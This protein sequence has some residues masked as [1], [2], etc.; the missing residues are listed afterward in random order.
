MKSDGF[1]TIRFSKRMNFPEMIRQ[2][3]EEDSS[4]EPGRRNLRSFKRKEIG[5]RILA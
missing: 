1:L 2:K 4:F 3:F 5:I